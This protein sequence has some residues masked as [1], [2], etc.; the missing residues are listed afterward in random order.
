MQN[1]LLFFKEHTVI[2]LA[3]ACVPWSGFFLWKLRDKLG[4]SGWKL[5]LAPF[6][7]VIV[8]LLS[9]VVFSI[10]HD[11]SQLQNFSLHHQGMLIVFPLFF[12]LAAKLLKKDWLD[13]S[14]CLTVSIPGIVA[15]LKC[16][17]FIHGCCYGGFIPG[18]TTRWPIREAFIILNCLICFVYLII[19]NK[20]HM[21]GIVLPCYLIVYGLFRII[22]VSLRADP[23]WVHNTGDRIFAYV[24]IILGL[25]LFSVIAELNEREKKHTVQKKKSRSS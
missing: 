17:C 6:I 8:G 11:I 5:V 12:P 1:I 22:E 14:D 13:V 25:L 4:L 24:S 15:L 10:I 20:K 21:K 19:I 9:I 23:T 2:I 7:Y 18:T 3:S 16:F